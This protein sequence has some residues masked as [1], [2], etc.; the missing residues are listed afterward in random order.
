MDALKRLID[1]DAVARLRA[2]DATLFD[3]DA[4]GVELAA[5]SMGWTDLAARASESY[6]VLDRLALE[7][8]EEGVTDVVLL[9]MGGSSLASLVIGDVL[10]EDGGVL[11][12]VFDT[13]APL[14]VGKAIAELD[15]ARTLYVVASKSGG[16]IEP[17]SL[18]A[19]F[20]EEADN[21]LG[22][23]AAGERF[24]A[25][26]DPG[27]SLAALAIADG[28][29]T[30]VSSPASV[31]GRFSAMTVFGLVTAAVL[32]I[33]FRSLVERAAAME[34]ACGLPA[35]ENPAAALA[36]FIGDAQAAGRD[37]LTVVASPA[38]ASFGLW[39]EQLV[40][41]SLGKLGTGVIPVVELSDE[42]PRDYGNDRAVVVLRLEGNERLAEWVPKLAATSP[43]IEL[44]L[45]DGFDIGAEFVRWEH[46]VSLLGPLLGV[47]PFGQPNVQ[48]AK[49]ATAAAL[50]GALATPQA[51]HTTPD[52][53][54]LTFAG[55]L[56][57]P[58][59]AEPSLSTAV[60]HALAAL[61]SSDFLCILAYL[62][63]DDALLAPLHEAV[64]RVSAATGHAVTLELGPRYLHSTG[65]LHKGGPDSGVFILVTTRDHAD[66]PVPGRE[67][68]LRDLHRAQA[69]GDLSTLTAAGRR[70]LRVDLPD[71]GLDSVAGLA[72]ALMDAAGVVWED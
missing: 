39:V 45:R 31:G 43:V 60:G 55:A 70:V 67:W 27:T 2:H 63:A 13:T 9:G 11:L 42:M 15:P 52:G 17:L 5:N 66:I 29:R 21:E 46:A 61:H 68:C 16:T 30:T 22:R 38:L 35:A 64:P 33:D 47:N 1:L 56:P 51:D 12:H 65:Q 34:A 58:T 72:R 41:E 54:A 4:A 37:K 57:V 36:A 44:V 8:T 62:P 71:A 40:A 23:Q 6:A 7:V 32:G 49:D 10:A 48:S 18:Y 53:T 50:S 3:T 59:H 24:I 28:F 26:T 25:I 20:R 69:E 14:T 19:I